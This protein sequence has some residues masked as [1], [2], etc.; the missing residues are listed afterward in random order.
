MIVATIAAAEKSQLY[1]IPPNFWDGFR[2]ADLVLLHSTFRIADSTGEEYAS[3]H[4]VHH[5]RFSRGLRG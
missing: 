4:L 1:R 5:Y 2:R 3:S